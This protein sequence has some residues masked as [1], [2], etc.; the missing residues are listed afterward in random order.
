LWNSGGID[1]IEITVCETVG[2][3]GRHSFYDSTGAL[4]D[5]VQNRMLQARLRARRLVAIAMIWAAPLTQ[6]PLM[7]WLL[8]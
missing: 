6:K 7:R 2:L 1:H 3:E 5:M 8:Q 4:R